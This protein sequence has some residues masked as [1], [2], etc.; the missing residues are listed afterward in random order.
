M[1]RSSTWR[2]QMEEQVREA[3]LQTKTMDFEWSLH[4]YQSHT[5]YK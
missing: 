4:I 5:I 3:G 1:W 2:E